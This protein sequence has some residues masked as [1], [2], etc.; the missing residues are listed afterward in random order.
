MS[1]FTK[2]IPQEGLDLV[3]YSGKD[4]INRLGK[5]VIEN[6]VLSILCGDNL[7]DLTESLTQEGVS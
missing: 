6:V 7:R 5:D 1:K 2:L 4:L 3:K